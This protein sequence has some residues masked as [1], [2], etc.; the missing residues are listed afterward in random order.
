[1]QRLLGLGC[2]LLGTVSD[3]SIPLGQVQVECDERAVLQTQCPQCGAIDLPEEGRAP[4]VTC[5]LVVSP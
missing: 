1:M 4:K 3:H 5:A 2:L